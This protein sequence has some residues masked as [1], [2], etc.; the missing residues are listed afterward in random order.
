VA[1]DVARGYL[2]AEDAARDY[3][4]VMTAADPPALDRRATEVRRGRR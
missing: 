1:R 2:T 4:V 3:D